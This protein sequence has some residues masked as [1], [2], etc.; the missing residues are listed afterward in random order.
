MIS[1]PLSV[2]PMSRPL[3]LPS[4]PVGERVAEGRVREIR[5]TLLTCLQSWKSK[6]SVLHYVGTLAGREDLAGVRPS[7]GAASSMVRNALDHLPTFLPPHAAAAGD[8]CSPIWLRL[9]RAVF[10]RGAKH[11]CPSVSIRG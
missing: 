11:P 6:L 4:P 1:N 5:F 3:A 8:G 7:S 2:V 9:R 10:F